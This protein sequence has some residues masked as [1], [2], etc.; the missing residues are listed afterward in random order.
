MTYEGILLTIFLFGMVALCVW[1]VRRENC[2]E[3]E[4]EA[5][6]VAR[7]GQFLDEIYCPNATVRR[8]PA[9]VNTSAQQRMS[10]ELAARRQ[11]HRHL[12][13]HIRVGKI[14]TGQ[15]G[16][17]RLALRTATYPPTQGANNITPHHTVWQRL[18][19]TTPR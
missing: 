6:S 3:R 18:F 9:E 10:A 11:N 5:L 1:Q 17:Q 2:M 19:C 14:W 12:W 13:L 8:D 15:C 16:R 7:L 4:S